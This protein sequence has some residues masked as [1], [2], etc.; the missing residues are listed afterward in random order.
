MTP[1]HRAWKTLGPSNRVRNPESIPRENSPLTLPQSQRT[2]QKANNWRI[3]LLSSP[4]LDTRQIS[5]L[6][7]S[8]GDASL[9]STGCLTEYRPLA[10]RSILTKVNSKRKLPFTYAINPYRGCEF[11]CRYCYARYAHEFLELTPKSSNTKSSLRR[12]WPGFLHRS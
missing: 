5:R 10:T 9:D 2:L 7:R 1:H 4:L 8:A 3:Y 11:A 6:A 12:M